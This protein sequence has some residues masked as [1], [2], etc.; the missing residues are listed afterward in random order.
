M[1][2]QSLRAVIGCGLLFAIT[3]TGYRWHVRRE[4]QKLDEGGERARETMKWGVTQQQID[5]GWRYEGY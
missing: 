1:A 4:N 2:G 5:M 3:I